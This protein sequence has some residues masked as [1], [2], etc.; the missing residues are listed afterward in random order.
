MQAITGRTRAAKTKST[1]KELR[2]GWIA[3]AGSELPQLQAVVKQALSKPAETRTMPALEAVRSA[4]AH[5]FERRSVVDERVLL[6]EALIAGRG[7]VALDGLKVTLEGREGQGSLI[8]KGTEV[9]SREGLETEKDLIVWARQGFKSAPW[10]IWG[11]TEG[12]GA[13]QATAVERVFHSTGQVVIVQGDAGTGKTTCLKAIVA[14]IER[15]GGQVFACAPSTGAAEVLRIELSTETATLQHLLK[16]TDLQR[17]NR[18]RVVLVDEAGLVSVRE[19]RDLTRRATIHGYRLLL[20]G[21]TKQ[22]NSVEAGDA[23]R[24]LQMHTDTPRYRLTEIRRQKDPD[25]RRA[26]RLLA[27]GEMSEAL[28]A[29]DRLGAV[30][31]IRETPKLMQTAAEDYVRTVQSGRTCLAISPVWKEI[32]AFNAEVRLHLKREGLLGNEEKPFEPIYPLKWTNEEKRQ[33]DNYQPG[34]RLTFHRDSDVFRK[35]ETVAVVSRDEGGLIVHTADNENLRLDP[36]RVKHFEVG[37]SRP[38]AIAVGET[39]QIRANLPAAKLINGER[40][41]VTDFLPD[42]SLALDDGRKMPAWFRQFSHGYATTSHAA[43]GKTVDRGILLMAEAGIAGANRKQ[44]YVSNSRFRED[45]VIYTTDLQSAREIMGRSGERKLAVEMDES[46]QVAM[47]AS[48][49]INVPP[50]TAA[51]VGR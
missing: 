9:A 21:D 32:H 49:R 50:S 51:K 47:G 30:K 11:P 8:R 44:A 26:V 29:F 15:S 6:R 36:K 3:E 31:V 34:D 40:V 45:Q 14:G 16:S 33:L 42:G 41:R 35:H 1:E 10:G 5:V 13:E 12:L 22:H 4:E 43:Q 39:L 27:R 17:A 23:L 37:V 28:A 20:V 38:A 2:D 24:C 19:L 7:L 18:G 25:Y 48:P 46:V